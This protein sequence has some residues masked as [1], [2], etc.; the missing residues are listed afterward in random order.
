VSSPALPSQLI[1]ADDLGAEPQKTDAIVASLEQGVVSWASAMA[2][3]SDFERACALLRERGLEE[4]IGAHLVLTHG[5]PL[6]DEM[7]ASTRFC[8][9]DGLFTG[10]PRTRR[11]LRMHGDERSV[12]ERELRAQLQR[13]VDAGLRVPHI[14]SHHHVHIQPALSPVIVFLAREFE[15]RRVRLAP[16]MSRH[17]GAGYR[18]YSWLH[19]HRLRRLGLATT[20]YVGSPSEFR[21]SPPSVGGADDFELVVHPILSESGAIEDHDAPGLSLETLLRSCF[22]DP[23]SA[24]VAQPSIR[25]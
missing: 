15:V 2:T 22:A 6:T 8:D 18:L 10:G 23:D 17:A 5:E 25:S 19:N 16:N 9:A 4:R 14:D 21:R 13:I 12:L 11:L 24:P 1:V 7:R 20:H 3:G